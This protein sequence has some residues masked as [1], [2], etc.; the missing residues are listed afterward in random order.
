ML[1]NNKIRK[2]TF[3]KERIEFVVGKIILISF[4]EFEMKLNMVLIVEQQWL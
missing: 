3:K 2:I 4:L 1:K